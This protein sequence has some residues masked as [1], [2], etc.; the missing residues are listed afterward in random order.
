MLESFVSNKGL[1]LAASHKFKVKSRVFKSWKN[2][3]SFMQSFVNLVY[4]D[5][6]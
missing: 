6:P 1:T 2:N 3:L 5:N 4:Q